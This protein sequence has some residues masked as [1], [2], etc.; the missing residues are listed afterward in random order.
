[1]QEGKSRIDH[2][3]REFFGSER[4]KMM[5]PVEKTPLRWAVTCL[6]CGCIVNESAVRDN[7]KCPVCFTALHSTCVNS[8]VRRLVETRKVE[9]ATFP[10]IPA[11]F[12][13]TRISDKQ[14]AFAALNGDSFLR[15]FE[16]E[17]SGAGGVE[18]MM[19]VRHDTLKDEGWKKGN[20]WA[21]FLEQRGFA[22]EDRFNAQCMG[23]VRAAGRHNLQIAYEIIAHENFLPN[24]YKLPIKRMVCT[25][26]WHS[27]KL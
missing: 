7:E 8:V 20:S 15:A 11:V 4:E 17:S 27:S 10:G 2:A 1:M 25:G 19:R 24:P 18:I 21:D 9:T 3:S 5:C 26:Q 16:V 14:W 13:S 12:V 23:Y 6:P 22:L